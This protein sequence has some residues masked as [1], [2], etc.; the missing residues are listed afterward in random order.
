[1]HNNFI[2]DLVWVRCDLLCIFLTRYSIASSICQHVNVV[3]RKCSTVRMLFK[4][5]HTI[6]YYV[7]FGSKAYAFHIHVRCNPCGLGYFWES[8][9][10]PNSSS[11]ATDFSV[12]HHLSP[13]FNLHL[14][15]CEI[16]W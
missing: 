14:C 9:E 6:N 8:F 7:L 10:K 11:L 4:K 1:M 3:Y 2:L 12:Y 13:I 15:N 16:Y 5:T